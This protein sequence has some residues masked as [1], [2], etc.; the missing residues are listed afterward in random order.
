[1]PSDLAFPS[2]SLQIWFNDTGT[3]W[4]DDRPHLHAASDEIFVVLEGTVV[5]AVEGKSV[6]VGPDEFCCFPAGLVH[7]I[8]AT[9]PPLRTLMIRAPSADDKIYPE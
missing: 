2:E 7:Q 4:S 6:R 3:R 8:V 1:M 5:V 9:E